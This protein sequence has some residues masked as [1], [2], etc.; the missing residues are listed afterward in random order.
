M[1]SRCL[2]RTSFARS[3]IGT[4]AESNLPILEQV[5]LAVSKYRSRVIV[6][7]RSKRLSFLSFVVVFTGLSVGI[8]SLEHVAG[9]IPRTH[10]EHS[11][12]GWDSPAWVA[13]IN[14]SWSNSQM[15]FDW[16]T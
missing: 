15:T 9:L 6:H 4:G 8:A 14:P 1:F 10:Q 2:Q 13:G 5:L 3:S 16:I 7:V 11:V 12:T